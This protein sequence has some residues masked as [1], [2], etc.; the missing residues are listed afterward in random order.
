MEVGDG[1]ERDTTFVLF[2]E[3]AEKLVRH[4]ARKFVEQLGAETKEVP[5]EMLALIEKSYVFR[6]KL[7]NHNLKD[8]R[9]D[10]T[11]NKIFE[12]AQPAPPPGHLEKVSLTLYVQ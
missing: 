2:D 12:P 1:G 10:Y 9:E 4:P 11:V 6:L 7:S 8:G 3:E 5:K